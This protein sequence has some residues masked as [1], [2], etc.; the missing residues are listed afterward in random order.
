MFGDYRAFVFH[1]ASVG[2][3]SLLTFATIYHPSRSFRGAQVSKYFLIGHKNA[4]KF[5]T[6]GCMVYF[7]NCEIFHNS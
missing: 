6:G 4:I 2:S 1:I 5:E 3:I 7:C